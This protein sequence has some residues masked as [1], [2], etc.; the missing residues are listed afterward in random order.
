MTPRGA[1]KPIEYDGQ[2]LSRL[3]GPET[4]SRTTFI[5]ASNP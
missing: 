2:A 3:S 1:T 4:L 5:P